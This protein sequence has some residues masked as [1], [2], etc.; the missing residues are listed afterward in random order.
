MKKYN[1][2]IADLN[3]CI[4]INPRNIKALKRLANLQIT[5]GNI[6]V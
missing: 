1:Y 4:N 6:G 5:L 3:R 2:A